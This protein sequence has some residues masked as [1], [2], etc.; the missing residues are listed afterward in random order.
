MAAL[1]SNKCPKC[2]KGNV[3]ENSIFN[4]F[5]IGKMKDSCSHC[6]FVYEKEP[7]FFF[8]A[9]YVSFA[10]IVAESLAVFI[11]SRFI[12]GLE[13]F[14]SLGITGLILILLFG[15]NFKLS[16]MIWIYMFYSKK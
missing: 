9:M 11:T 14:L 3:F 16:R 1:F 2:N 4:L 8:G 10:L 13:W 12:I 5:R 15:V 7:G 6:N